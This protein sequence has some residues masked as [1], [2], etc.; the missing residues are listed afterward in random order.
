MRINAWSE[1]T[2]MFV[3]FLV[4]VFLQLIYPHL[5]LPELASWQRLLIVMGITTVAWVSVTLL[6]KPTEA[7]KC[8]E[9]Q[10]KIHTSRHDIAWGVLAMFL[11]CAAV[12]S[13]MF[14]AGYWIYGETVLAIVT[15]STFA[16]STAAVIPVVKRLNGKV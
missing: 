9:F 10:D 6:T 14:A 11:T 13:A 5:G 3:S 2:A 16:V 15:T 4:A 1:I 8:K 12:Y 7:S